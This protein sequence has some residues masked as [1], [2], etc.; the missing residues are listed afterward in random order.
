[1]LGGMPLPRIPATRQVGGPVALRSVIIGFAISTLLTTACA[2]TDDAAG[3]S[4]TSVDATV[5]TTTTQPATTAA[6]TTSAASTTAAPTTSTTTTTITPAD[7][8]LSLTRVV[9][10]PDP[11]LIVTN[12]GSTSIELADHWLCQRPDYARLPA[13]TVEP[14]DQVAI[15]LTS[16][17]PPDLVAVTATIELGQDIGGLDRT[18]GELALYVGSDF[19][20]ATAISDY[21]AWGSAGHGRE[22]VAVD[23]GIWADGAFIDIA[24]EALSIS[25][26][27]SPGAGAEDWFVD[28]GG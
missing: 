6:P 19:D 15:A 26:G 9:F 17:L 28:L 13:L 22:S 18:G 1:M 5:P 25:S 10:E 12:V 14:A 4:T 7:G 16:V 3:T 2:T 20:A 24:P 8:S 11:Y 21:V 27:G 23:A